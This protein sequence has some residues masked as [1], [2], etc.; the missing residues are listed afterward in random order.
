VTRPIPYYSAS[1]VGNE[2]AYLTDAAQSNKTGADGPFAARCCRL[3][4][5]RFGI[6]EVL[7]TTSCTAALEIACQLAEL[8]P[9]DEVLMPSFTY[10]STANAVVRLGARPV[11]V[12]IRPDTLNLDE[13]QVA[14]AI[15]PR[16]RAMIAVHYA[17]VACAM[18]ELQALAA[19]AGLFLIE[20]AAHAVDAWYG[21]RAL[22]SIGY[23]GCYSFHETKNCSC[24]QG[25][26]LCINDPE[27]A[28][29]AER[30][31]AK[32]TNRRSFHR[33]LVDKYIW[34]D[35]GSS[36]GANEL[37]A[38]F[39]LGQLEQ[40]EALTARRRAQHGL[41]RSL[42]QPYADRG[43]FDLPA[44]PRGD[45]DNGHIFY[46][47]LP[48]REQRQ[49]LAA[50]LANAGIQAPFHYVPLH[51]SPMG[52]RVG[53]VSALL[54]QT[55]SIAGRLLRLPLFHGLLEEQQRFIAAQIGAFLERRH[56]PSLRKSG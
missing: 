50:C 40:L 8:R 12:D 37:T 21:H 53:I 35:L 19:E 26:A 23:L 41:Y 29:R 54:T 31:W 48:S 9:G 42:L 6:G 51:D 47:L 3:L 25:G 32:G 52:R 11:F 43:W 44:N 34:T 22:G 24:G 33:G 4:E 55:E 27:M 36:Y 18:S 49:E 45:H 13:R 5:E 15:T 56:T 38:A 16:T 17:G 2:L 14:S 7:L 39:L 1:L 46:V 20:D 28:E 10:V 30:I